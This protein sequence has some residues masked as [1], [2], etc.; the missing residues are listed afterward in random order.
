MDVTSLTNLQIGLIGLAVVWTIVWKGI[1]LWK[2]AQLGHR[3]WF[4]VLLILNTL[5]ILEIIYIYFVARKYTVE[6]VEK[7]E[8]K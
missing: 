3:R 1:A 6:T 8:E 5:G 7:L 4:V 2:A